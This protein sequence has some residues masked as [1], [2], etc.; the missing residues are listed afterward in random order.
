MRSLKKYYIKRKAVGKEV[1]ARERF[2][3]FLDSVCYTLLFIKAVKLRLRLAV[4]N[5]SQ[6]FRLHSS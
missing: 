2:D 4:P 6:I 1:A 5:F 3:I